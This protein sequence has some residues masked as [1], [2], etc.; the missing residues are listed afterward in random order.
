MESGEKCTKQRAAPAPAAGGS[1]VW[2]FL[3]FS[4]LPRRLCY[5]AREYTVTA[6]F[7]KE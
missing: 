3:E 7:E 1:F 2:E 6:I 4:G 5:N